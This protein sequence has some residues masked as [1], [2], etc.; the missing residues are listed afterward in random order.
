MDD[1][2]TG[3]L[4]LLTLLAGYG[5]SLILTPEQQNNAYY[6]EATNQIGIFYGGLSGTRLTA[7]PYKENKTGYVRCSSLWINFTG[8]TPPTPS[9]PSLKYRCE[10][11]G[12]TRI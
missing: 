7:Y 4:M 6:C 5:G 10:I 8:I 1:K 3:I 2:L 11:A 9:S 12:C